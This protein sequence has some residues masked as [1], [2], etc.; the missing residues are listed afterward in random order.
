MFT[1][2]LQA[3]RIFAL[4]I[5]LIASYYRYISNRLNRD[6][7]AFKKDELFYIMKCVK[8]IERAQDTLNKGFSFTLMIATCFSFIE[9][10][11]SYHDVIDNLL[12]DNKLRYGALF[13]G[14]YLIRLITSF[15][16]Y[17]SV[18]W[19]IVHI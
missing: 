4:C 13:F 17:S 18:T 15:V 19:Q 7:K 9:L 6:E 11:A 12:L 2:T 5:E 3:F 8:S 1:Q 10:F 16:L 14:I